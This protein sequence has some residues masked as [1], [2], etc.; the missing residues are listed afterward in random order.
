MLLIRWC[1]STIPVSIFI[2]PFRLNERMK[3]YYHN[4]RS[5]SMHFLLFRCSVRAPACLFK[6]FYL[7]PCIFLLSL[8]CMGK[9]LNQIKSNDEK[10]ILVNNMKYGLIELLLWKRYEVALVACE[11]RSL[12]CFGSLYK[13]RKSQ[14][15]SNQIAE[16][17]FNLSSGCPLIYWVSYTPL[18]IMI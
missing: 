10:I 13:N 7:L 14:N 5:N 2:C 16:S 15:W 18:S 17:N 9:M 6:R 3:I 1:L 8:Y 11:F 4:F 12:A